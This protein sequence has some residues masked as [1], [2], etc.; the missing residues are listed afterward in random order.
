MLDII[1][2]L[3]EL[4]IELLFAMVVGVVKGVLELRRVTDGTKSER[5]TS[6]YVAPEMRRLRWIARIVIIGY[7][8]TGLIMPMLLTA[9]SVQAPAFVAEHP[10]A[11]AGI[12]FGGLW[13]GFELLALVFRQKRRAMAA[14]LAES[15]VK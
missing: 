7:L 2:S 13:V 11:I 9:S 1:Y 6:A 14:R 5:Q 12:Y 15:R 10:V 3:F 4:A 8:L